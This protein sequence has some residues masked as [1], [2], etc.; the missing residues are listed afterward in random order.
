MTETTGVARGTRDCGEVMTVFVARADGTVNSATPEV[1]VG[2]ADER[3][4]AIGQIV[5]YKAVVLVII[6]SPWADV[7][8]WS[9]VEEQL[10]TVIRVVLHTVAVVRE[11]DVVIVAFE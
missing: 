2:N 8:Q 4:S 6:T 10:V 9:T 5:V 11:S 1:T 7:G 3:A